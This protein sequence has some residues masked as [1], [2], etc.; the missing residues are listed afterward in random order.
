MDN[1]TITNLNSINIINNSTI[2][3]SIVTSKTYTDTSI[4]SLIA[5]A[6]STMDNLYEIS[7][8]LTTNINSIGDSN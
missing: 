5:N 7:Q 6:P 2:P 8:L 3:A 1:K 4:S